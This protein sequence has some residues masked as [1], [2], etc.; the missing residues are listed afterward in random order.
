MHRLLGDLV[1]IRHAEGLTVL[2]IGG[3]L[4]GQD[5]TVKHGAPVGCFLIREYL[6]TGTKIHE[7]IVHPVYYEDRMTFVAVHTSMNLDQADAAI[8]DR[9]QKKFVDSLVFPC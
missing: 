9:H 2:C 3:P 5:Y 1:A 6:A 8:A 7:Y 4:D